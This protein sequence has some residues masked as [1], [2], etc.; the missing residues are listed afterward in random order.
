MASNF[1]A[2]MPRQLTNLRIDEVSSV[3]RGAGKGVRVLLM[4][5]HAD[6]QK[7]EA[8]PEDKQEVAH[9][10]LQLA[11]G[12]ILADGGDTAAVVECFKQFH[13][14]LSNTAPAEET[15]MTKEEISKL[16]AE[17]LAKLSAKDGPLPKKDK[18]KPAPDADG[19]DDGDA[20]KMLAKVFGAER[21]AEIVAEM[22]TEK[23]EV[24]VV[25]KA[26]KDV[27][28]A[29]R[30]A[31]IEEL[32][33]HVNDLRDASQRVEFGK[34]AVAIGLV[35]ADGEKLRK[36]YSGDVDSLKFMED[37][38]A[39]LN[40]QVAKAGLFNEIGSGG[41]AAAS[42]HD[43]LKSK[44]LELRKGNPKLTEAQAYVQAMDLYPEIA[45]REKDERDAKIHKM[46]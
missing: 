22:K 29:K 20:E 7:A 27:E 15:A 1:P 16:I 40:V 11:V 14:F 41:G 38:I 2:N 13:E 3:D 36:A 17:E 9:K 8:M 26:A 46:V 35:E 19:D 31:K 25:E 43:E 5:R 6:A 10:A 21:A 28:I 4:K 34:R 37:T 39:K 33:K 45:K 30:D 18:G 44:A 23:S 32:T 42:A 12:S 24:P